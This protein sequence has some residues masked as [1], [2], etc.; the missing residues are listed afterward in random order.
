MLQT[1]VI[2]LNPSLSEQLKDLERDKY[3]TLKAEQTIPPID[4]K[5][6]PSFWD[7]IV[8]KGYDKTIEVGGP[9]TSQAGRGTFNFPKTNKNEEIKDI[10]NQIFGVPKVLFFS[11]VG[12]VGFITVLL[13]L[14]RK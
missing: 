7:A 13:L 14:N 2:D 12:T 8:F 4:I 11:A 1:Q 10:E 5:D 3:G 9:D 6:N